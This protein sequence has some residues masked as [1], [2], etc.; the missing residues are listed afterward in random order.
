M[1]VHTSK[2][3]TTIKHIAC[4]SAAEQQLTQVTVSDALSTYLPA[5]N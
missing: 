3:I 2:R 5:K 1:F 4:V